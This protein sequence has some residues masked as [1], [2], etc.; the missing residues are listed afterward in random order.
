MTARG[1]GTGVLARILAL[2]G[3]LV[4]ALGVAVPAAVAAPRAV[5]PEGTATVRGVLLLGSPGTPV[6]ATAVTLHGVAE[7]ADPLTLTAT[8]DAK[9]RFTFARLAGGDAWTY[10]L[11]SLH[12]GTQFS[13]DVLAVKSGETLTTTLQTYDTTTDGNAV[14]W[15]AWLVWIDQESGGIAVQQDVAMRNSGTTAYTGTAPVANAPDKGKAAVEL[16]VTS[17]AT[18]LSYLGSFEVCCDAVVGGLW[19]HTRPVPPGSSSGTLRY[20]TPTPSSLTFPVQRTTEAFQ[21]LVPQGIEVSAPQLASA[22]TQTDRGITYQVFKGGPFAAG[23]TLT[24]TVGG[25]SSSPAPW[26]ALG[27]GGLVVIGAAV[28]FWLRSRRTP[29]APAPAPRA[30]KGSAKAAAKARPAAAKPAPK[31]P[32]V[33]TPPKPAAAPAAAPAGGTRATSSTPKPAPA[34]A[35]PTAAGR[36]SSPADDPSVL[37]DELAMLDLAHENGALPDE[38]SYQRVR[39]SLVARLVAALGEDPDALGADRPGH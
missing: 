31:K 1:T 32:P 15:T 2:T 17:G 20:E 22:G 25:T 21:L 38:A 28:W 33:A 18:N 30:P 29:P 36:A 35:A 10:T 4:L 23:T 26:I 8:T 39:E 9:G 3:S 5:S 7:G 12:T 37:A 34:A 16:P 11:T 6:P 13:S 19:Q 24:V 14:T 27:L